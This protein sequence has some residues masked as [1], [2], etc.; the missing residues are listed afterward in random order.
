VLADREFRVIF[1]AA[2]LSWVG[3]YLARAAVTL[4]VYKSTGSVSASAITFAI[5]YLPWILGGPILATLAERYPPRRVMVLAD[6]L[7]AALIAAVIVH[8][9][10]L[11]SIWLLLFLAALLN[12]PFDASRASLMSRIFTDDRYVLAASMQNTMLQVAVLVGYGPGPAL[13]AYHPRA[14]LLADAATFAISGLAIR[15]G[16]RDRPAVRVVQQRRR[17]L[18][19][20]AEGFA[21]I[22][23]SRVLRSIALVVLLL[24]TLTI[25]PEGLA[26][27]WAGSM[28]HPWG[29][30][31][32]SQA[33]I[34][35]TS[36]IGQVIGGFLIN[37]LIAPRR[38]QRLLPYLAILGPAALIPA[39]LHPNSLVIACCCVLSG[40]AGAG[41]MPN[42]IGIFARVVP[43]DYRTRSFGV[44]QTAIQ[45][46]QALGVL[47]A[48]ALA[49]GYDLATVVGAWSVVG[50]LLMAVVC[51]LVWPSPARVDAAALTPAL[52][53][54]SRPGPGDGAGHESPGDGAAQES[55]GDGAAQ[56]TAAADL[57]TEGARVPAQDQGARPA[58]VTAEPA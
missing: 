53:G 7:R 14:T 5:S 27:A 38:R 24:V 3:D 26:A 25:V 17:L 32:V 46:S 36:P 16:V 31:A 42:A 40:V 13:A 2:G 34:M 52:P 45:V 47:A 56:E 28:E 48:G 22:L 19:E 43:L 15:L 44:M 6:L 9:L 18:A 37:R 12:S 23:R 33:L 29:G 30:R 41:V 49:E 21:F 58:S 8:G 1:A 20:T 35:G 11:W 4:L 57:L 55:P 51:V 54:R 50:T 10:P 39:L